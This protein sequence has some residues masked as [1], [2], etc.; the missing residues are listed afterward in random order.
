MFR[1]SALPRLDTRYLFPYRLMRTTASDINDAPWKSFKKVTQPPVLYGHQ[2]EVIGRRRMLYKPRGSTE[3][4]IFLWVRRNCEETATTSLETSEKERSHNIPLRRRKHRT[5]KVG[6][7]QPMNCDETLERLTDLL[8]VK[9]ELADAKSSV[10][11]EGSYDSYLD[12][13]RNT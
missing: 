7:R 8:K 5:R 10:Y 12:T 13:S 3:D 9:H 6:G 2:R 1:R 11:S 4:G